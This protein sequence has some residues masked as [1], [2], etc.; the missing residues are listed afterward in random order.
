MVETFPS[1]VNST[2]ILRAYYDKAGKI[3]SFLSTAVPLLSHSKTLS[4]PS[5]L[6]CPILVTYKFLVGWYISRLTLDGVADG[7]TVANKLLAWV[8]LL[9]LSAEPTE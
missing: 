6:Q 4:T 1:L 9:P 3:E 8:L 5:L 7:G 2:R